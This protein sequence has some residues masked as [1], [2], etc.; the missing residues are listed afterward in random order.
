MKMAMKHENDEF[1]VI[2]LKHVS[3]LTFVVNLR[4]TPKLWVIANENDFKSE[5][6]FFGHNSQIFHLTSHA[7]RH[8]HPK[9]WAIAHEYDHNTRK[10]PLFGHTSQICIGYYEP[11]KSPWNP[12][13]MGNSS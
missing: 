6:Q 7:N 4:R 2:T 11:C 12:K 8:R 5:K 13:N 3:G 10:R 1:L 9:L